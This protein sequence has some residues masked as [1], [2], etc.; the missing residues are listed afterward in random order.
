[1]DCPAMRSLAFGAL[2]LAAVAGC[3]PRTTSPEAPNEPA[4]EPVAALPV[5]PA[6]GLPAEPDARVSTDA[7]HDASD[8][9]RSCRTDAD[10][11]VK[12]VGNCCGYY[13]MCVNKDARTDPEGVRAR[14]EKDG[15]SSVCGFPEIRGCRCLQGRCESFTEGAVDR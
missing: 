4:A 13:P 8:P 11:A 1:M 6:P 3:T 7:S 15:L 9:D 14:C 12:N 5:A 2:I 10:C